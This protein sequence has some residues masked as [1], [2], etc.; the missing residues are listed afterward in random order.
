[1]DVSVVLSRRLTLKAP[2][3]PSIVLMGSCHPFI[4]CE[5]L[6]L[7]ELLVALAKILTPGHV[8]DHFPFNS[9]FVCNPSCV[10][11][12]W[13]IT[14]WGLALSNSYVSLHLSWTNRLS[15]FVDKACFRYLLQMLPADKINMLVITIVLTG[16]INCGLPQKGQGQTHQVIEWYCIHYSF[17][18]IL[19]HTYKRFDR[20]TLNDV[21][22][23][24]NYKY[25]IVSVTSL[26]GRN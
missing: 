17:T 18:T 3:H 26:S 22:M 9:H 13:L 12:I 7:V 25:S 10:A 8:L 14:G 5:W 24:L 16:Y 23:T 2:R 11:L 4:I 15:L 1:M 21:L 19:R 6:V 20:Q